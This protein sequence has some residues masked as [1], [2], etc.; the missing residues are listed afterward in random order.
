MSV[1][2]GIWSRWIIMRLYKWFILWV[3]IVFV[4]VW[5]LVFVFWLFFN[6]VFLSFIDVCLLCMFGFVG[7]VNYECM[8]G[9]EMFWNVFMICFI[10]V[11]VCVLLLMILLLLLV[12]LVQKKLLGI[13]FF[14]MMFYFFVIVL[15]VV[16]VF[17]WIWL[18]DSCGIINQ[19]FEFL[20]LIDQL[21]VFF[22]DCWLLL[23]CV[24]LFIVWKGF[25]Y[26]MV[27]YLVVFGNVGKELYEV[28]MFDGVGF[29]C[30]FL[31]VMIFLVCGVMFLIFVFIVVF[32]MC[33]FVEFDVLFKS[34]GGLGGY[35]ML[36]VML[37]CQVGFGLNGNIG[38]V[39]VIS[40]VLFFFIFILFVVIV[41]MNCEK[42]V[43]V[44]V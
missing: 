31:F 37:I 34:M 5:V 16:V 32:V 25:G 39:F 19:M 38:Y 8:F 15:V 23:G 24:I 14:C 17:I 42:K 33:V 2:I 27:V 40:V 29:F 26:Y 20:G 13:L 28:V 12:F 4:V 22:V 41:F 1:N 18:F 11:V 21:M 30:C 3:F 7:G 43:K 10:Y 35:D 6:M 44:F 36:F 9:D